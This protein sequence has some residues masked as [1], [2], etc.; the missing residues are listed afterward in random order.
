MRNTADF[1]PRL[2]TSSGAIRR[3]M[4]LAA[5][6]IILAPCLFACAGES[7]DHPAEAAHFSYDAAD[8][9]G[10]AHWGELEGAN[11]CSSGRNQSPVDISGVARAWQPTFQIAYSPTPLVLAN[12]G[13]TVQ[14]DYAGGSSLRLD[15]K[16]FYLAQFPFHAPSEHQIQGRGTAL[17]AHLVHK[18]DTG[19]LAVLGVLIRRGRENAF[20]KKFWDRMPAKDCGE[21]CTVRDSALE[22]NVRDLLPARL[23]FYRY[24]GSLTTPPCSE[25]LRWLVL[26]DS[27]QASPEQIE[28]FNQTIGPSAR[29]VQP[30]YARNVLDIR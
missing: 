13:H 12:K 29:P 20:L 18:S 26:K 1:S 11:L 10:P 16:T 5:S 30:L 17:E 7:Q 23:D 4:L 14:A 8:A 9:H 27:V 22:I 15:G 19:E 28:R 21:N 2:A 25:G 6:A 24:S 3:R